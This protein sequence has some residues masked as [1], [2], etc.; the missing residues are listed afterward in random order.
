MPHDVEAIRGK[1]R[2]FLDSKDA[3]GNV[4]SNSKC[5]VYVFY[6]YDGEP[7][8]V[9]KTNERLRSR[10]LRHLTNQRT[11]AVAM[12]VLD[13]YEV[14][15]IEMYP[16]PD[17]ERRGRGESR[18]DYNKRMKQTL[19]SAEYTVFQKVLRESPIGAVLNEKSI[20]KMPRIQLPPAHRG[21]MVPEELFEQRKHPDIRIAWR[22]NTVANLARVLSERQTSKGLRKILL[23]QAQRLE[24]LA[25]QR[26]GDFHD[27]PEEAPDGE[28][29]DEE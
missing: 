28:T 23:V 2:A 26:L 1:I 4:P 14:A 25:R 11:D 16:F 13:P 21:S 19:C 3:D 8:Y 10:S 15:E 18:D 6:D 7:I 5:G 29:G 12:N 27:M 22:A 20:P 24:R 17:L 9:G